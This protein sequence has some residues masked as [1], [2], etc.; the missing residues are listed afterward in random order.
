M[1]ANEEI[2]RMTPHG[3]AFRDVSGEW[4]F[5]HSIEATTPRVVPLVSAVQSRCGNT[6]RLMANAI[7]KCLEGTGAPA[8]I[9]PSDGPPSCQA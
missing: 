5:E 1:T 6:A 3:R 4:Q 8:V 9:V 7:N 2:S